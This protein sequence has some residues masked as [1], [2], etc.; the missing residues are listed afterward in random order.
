MVALLTNRQ[1]SIEEII[2]IGNRDQSRW[3]G[4]K[5]RGENPLASV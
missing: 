5:S 2:R 3:F 4:P 1:R